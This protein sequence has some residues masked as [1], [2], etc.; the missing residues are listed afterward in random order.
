MSAPSRTVLLLYRRADC[1]LCDEARD[2]LQ[3]SMEE[4]AARGEPVPVAREV[5][6]DSDP[7]LAARFGHRIPVL[8]A[9]D[10]ELGM[11]MSGRQVRAFLDRVMGRLA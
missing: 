10:H 2:V 11:A 7:E 1:P 4:R 3:A 6:V 5:D 8:V 9:G